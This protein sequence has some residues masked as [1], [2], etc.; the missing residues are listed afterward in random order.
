M[1]YFVTLTDL[2]LVEI[3]RDISGSQTFAR[4]YTGE[5]M[6]KYY[7]ISLDKYNIIFKFIL[8]LSKRSYY[9]QSHKQNRKFPLQF[10]SAWLSAHP[11]ALCI[12]LS[13]PLNC[14]LKPALT[15]VQYIYQAI[16]LLLSIL[17]VYNCVC[18]YFVGFRCFS[19]V[20]SKPG[21]YHFLFTA[22]HEGESEVSAF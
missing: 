8:A 6:S 14:F 17:T 2:H 12:W 20:F 13:L 21:K 4:C 7:S 18:T 1:T 16:T 5:K 22:H 3:N 9:W 15:L 10:P 19:Q 11:N